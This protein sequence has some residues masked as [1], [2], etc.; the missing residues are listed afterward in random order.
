[1][2]YLAQVCMPQSR[3]L[4]RPPVLDR[5][6]GDQCCDAAKG[7]RSAP[8]D[9]GNVYFNNFWEATVKIACKIVR[10]PPRDQRRETDADLLQA[11]QS[12]TQ[13]QMQR[14]LVDLRSGIEE[15]RVSGS[16]GMAHSLTGRVP[17]APGRSAAQKQAARKQRQTIEAYKFTRRARQA[18]EK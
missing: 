5:G 11:R 8:K 13:E 9:I 15:T 17:V 7:P 14:F 1:M 18:T 16:Q 4:L 12:A 3:G 2:S 6:N 10:G